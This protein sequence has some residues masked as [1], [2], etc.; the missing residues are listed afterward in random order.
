MR[1][2]RAR[3]Q[4]QGRVTSRIANRIL[5]EARYE[6]PQHEK[7]GMVRYGVADV[8]L[9]KG[10]PAPANEKATTIPNQTP[11]D[12]VADVQLVGFM[13]EQL[14][15]VEDD[16]YVPGNVHE[17][18]WALYAMGL[19]V[20]PDAIETAYR[21]ARDSFG[22][23]VEVGQ[24][25]ADG[26]VVVDEPVEAN[27][28]VTEAAEP[29][30]ITD[31]VDDDPYDSEAAGFAPMDADAPVS[32]EVLADMFGYKHASGVRQYIE[33]LLVKTKELLDGLAG[34]KLDALKDRAAEDFVLGL[35]DEGYIDDEN[36]DTML[37]SLDAVKDLDTYRFWL[38]NAFLMPAMAKL[39]KDRYARVAGE[40]ESLGVPEEVR[41][42][43]WNQVAGNTPKSAE[44]IQKR[45]QAKTQLSPEEIA[46]M[47]DKIQSSMA[48]LENAAKIRG[49]IVDTAL[50]GYEALSP[51]KRKSLL[52]KSMQDKLEL[53]VL[54]K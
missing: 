4:A 19:Q 10:A 27:E 42:T 51:A 20:E 30:Y 47:S 24:E 49:N 14:P 25:E 5:F 22:P 18:A 23:A 35:H 11:I 8:P 15:P 54:V 12:P 7:P 53:D 46:K 38:N 36:L 28:P 48:S 6:D 32:L 44:L 52:A 50:F 29:D 39:E 13:Q 34:G 41:Q 26:R 21:T 33:R 40:L 37:S 1:E 2:N 3:R 43:V 17:L 31:Y 45:L 16:S 9:G